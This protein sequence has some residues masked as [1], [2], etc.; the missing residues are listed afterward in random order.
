MSR[1]KIDVPFK[2]DAEIADLVEQ[3]EQCRW[4]YERW[5]HRAHVAV[6]V[7]Y[8]RAY[9][10]EEAVSRVK[11]NI[12]RYNA[13]SGGPPDGYHETLTLLF[14]RAVNDWVR[15]E[16]GRSAAELIDAITAALDMAWVR[17]HY[18]KELLESERARTT[19][20]DPDVKAL[21]FS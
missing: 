18:S 1:T 16:K 14:M 11:R 2:N 20:A 15:R 10:Y 5:T 21:E 13:A 17:T 8:L 3:F 4:P 19:W 6:A 7:A 9:P 12:P